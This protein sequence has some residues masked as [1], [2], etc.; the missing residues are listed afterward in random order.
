THVDTR[1][2][3]PRLAKFTG[4]SPFHLQ[5]MFKKA[6]GI[7]P[8][9]YQAA[10]RLSDFKSNLRSTAKVV[11]AAYDSGYSSSS[12]VSENA[13]PQLGMTPASYG[14]N[15]K[16]A[17]ITYAIFDSE[18]GKVLIA[19]TQRGIC[20]LKFGASASELERGLSEEFSAAEIN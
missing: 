1:V 15:G 14:K 16:G 11:D 10:R 8:Q 17:K 20:S 9:Q 6:L 2:T 4:Y 13:T 18:L 12:R 19:E 3:L 7:S 5:R